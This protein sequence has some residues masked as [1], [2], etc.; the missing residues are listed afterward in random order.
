MRPLISRALVGALCIGAAGCALNFDSTH[1]GV[2]ATL[3][4]P[5]LAP[6]AGTAFS[7]TKH[8]V[9]VLWGAFTAGEPNIEDVLAGQLGAGGGIARLRIHVRARWSDL[10]LTALTLGFLSPRSVTFEGVVVPPGGASPPA[11]AH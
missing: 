11:A 6:A 2:P 4:E 10:L 9:F 3:A 1:L 7:V 5:A 8:P